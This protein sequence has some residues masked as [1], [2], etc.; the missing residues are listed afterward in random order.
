MSMKKT[1]YRWIYF[2]VLMVFLLPVFFAFIVFCLPA[3]YDETYL[4]ALRDKEERLENVQGKKLII[5]GGSSVAFG[6]RSD[7]MEEQLGMQVVNWGLYAPLGSRT[8]LEACFDQINEG[9]IVIFCPEQNPETLSFSFQAE[10]MW[11]AMDGNWFKPGIFSESE[12]KQLLG[13]FPRFAVSKLK[14]MI[15]GKPQGS[16]IYR[17][18]SFNEY[19]DIESQERER[20]QM[21]E[22]YD[23]AQLIDFSFFPEED[24]VQYLNDYAARVKQRGAD[25]YYR[26]CPMNE[27]AVVNEEKMD[28]WFL[29]LDKL[30]EFEIL[31]DP[32][33]SV[34]ESGWFFDTNFHLNASGAVVN[35]YYFVRDIKAQLKDS[36][37][38]DI[39]LPEMPKTAVQTVTGDNSDESCFIYTMQ[40]DSV[41]I[42]G[43]TEEG[44]EREELTFP[45]KHDGKAITAV[46][47]RSLKECE[48]LR[49]VYVFG[50]ITLYD[51]CF[52]GCKT[53][54][55]II[56]QGNPSEITVGRD[57]LRG[58]D[59]LMYTE[60]EDSYRLD[61]SWAQYSDKIKKY[62][63]D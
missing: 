29:R 58:T 8:M 24:F 1:V 43:V 55:K 26:F 13:A 5:V 61:Y 49:T 4:G 40:D 37:V 56:L 2:L 32:H 59:A 19:G 23:A 20:N 21:T 27:S 46:Q 39:V 9:D 45:Q 14:Y 15:E 41:I 57:L 63:Q 47:E 34:M 53:L 31:G 54:Q 60:D 44:K 52:S 17:R 42:T 28:E 50:G 51:G 33:Q 12:L 38:T 7:L 35:T 18:N 6:I 11:Q 16:G 25:F 10:E 3:Q 30:T 22:G 36:S 48:N 62:Y